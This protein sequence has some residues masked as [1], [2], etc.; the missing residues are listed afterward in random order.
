MKALGRP[1]MAVNLYLIAATLDNAAPNDVLIRALSRILRE[2]YDIQFFLENSQIRCLAHFVNLVVQKILAALN[3]ADEPEVMDYYLPNKD[4]PFHYE[5]E[6]HPNLRDLENE[7]FEAEADKS[8]EEDADA[9]T[10]SDMAAELA[11]LSPLQKLRLTTTRI[12][13]S[14][15]RS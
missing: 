14:P 7:R 2:K 9:E 12:C 6:E 11:N 3:E 10:M 4:L 8:D 13:G 1:P 15:Q 5:P